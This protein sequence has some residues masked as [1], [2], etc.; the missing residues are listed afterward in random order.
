MMWDCSVRPQSF[1][2]CCRKQWGCT[3]VGTASLL[4]QL[5][6]FWLGCSCWV[7]VNSWGGF[8]DCLDREH[9]L[10]S[11]HARANGFSCPSVLK[12]VQHGS[13]KAASRFLCPKSWQAATYTLAPC[14][15]IKHGDLVARCLS[16][17]KDKPRPF[18]APGAVGW[19]QAERSV[20]SSRELMPWILWQL[21][22]YG[23]FIYF[24]FFKATPVS[25]IG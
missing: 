9:P 17:A 2:P 3:G 7:A 10:P 19:I 23:G 15:R 22:C 4:S 13:T 24:S 14:G 21:L 18:V 5:S 1:V 16:Q 12:Q 20:C 11:S 6:W 8:G 25:M